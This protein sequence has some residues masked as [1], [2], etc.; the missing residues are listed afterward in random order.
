[1]SNTNSGVRR[2]HQRMLAEFEDAHGRA[3]VLHMPIDGCTEHD[4]G[5]VCEMLKGTLERR[6]HA[7]PRR[8]HG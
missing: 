5:K 7:G 2:I 4:L 6:Q 8:L 3:S 1:M